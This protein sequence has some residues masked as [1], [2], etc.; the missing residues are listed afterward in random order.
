MQ[1]LSESGLSTVVKSLNVY[2]HCRK[3]STRDAK[4]LQGDAVSVHDGYKVSS[5][6]Y[7]GHRN[8][9][10]M[11]HAG[12]LSNFIARLVFLPSRVQ[13]SCFEGCPRVHHVSEKKVKQQKKQGP[14]GTKL[15]P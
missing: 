14:D 9:T 7:G 3:I 4:R 6:R 5:H 12:T 13:L 1:T 8:A 11:V 10:E 2:E 15:N